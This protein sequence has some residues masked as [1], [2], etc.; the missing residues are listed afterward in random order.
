MA[1]E[2]DLTDEH[3]AWLRDNESSNEDAQ[4]GFLSAGTWDPLPTCW[5]NNAEMARGAAEMKRVFKE[6]GLPILKPGQVIAH[7]F[8][9]EFGDDGEYA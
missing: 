3:F 1:R 5:K 6:V 7:I 4:F 9:Q 2:A 8:K